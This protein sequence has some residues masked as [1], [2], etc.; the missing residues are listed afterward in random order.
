MSV[1][2]S[3]DSA[4]KQ[5]NET[6]ALTLRGLLRMLRVSTKQLCSE[7]WFH[8]IWIDSV[9]ICSKAVARANAET[10]VANA[11]VELLFGMLSLVSDSSIFD[12][13]C[14]DDV[15]I[16]NV[17]TLEYNKQQLWKLTVQFVPWIC[18][19]CNNV[20]LALTVLTKLDILYSK[21]KDFEFRYSENMRI[22]L[23]CM[24]AI[25]RPCSDLTICSD[26]KQKSLSREE[27]VD[28]KIMDFFRR[29]STVDQSLYAIFMSTLC[30][31]CFS[32]KSCKF[33]Y[34]CDNNSPDVQFEVGIRSQH[35]REQVC[36]FLLGEL[37]GNLT[38]KLSKST[39]VHLPNIVRR[40]FIID[41]G[42]NFLGSKYASI[43][44]GD[45]RIE[46]FE[47]LLLPRSSEVGF[48]LRI[49]RQKHSYRFWEG[50][51][52][53]WI[54]AG[55][56]V[57]SELK[58]LI[59][60]FKLFLHTTRPT[61]LACDLESLKLWLATL[62]GMVTGQIDPNETGKSNDD[63]FF[64]ELKSLFDCTFMAMSQQE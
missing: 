53:T 63:L 36:E 51:K 32:I 11:G 48:S 59:R 9:E 50:E 25:S 21:R 60:A 39:A 15:D 17:E 20:E 49:Q 45:A 55:T 27:T 41:V 47:T 5:W 26:A 61:D 13:E 62:F 40:R 42:S 3:R 33:V 16:L 12:E 23:N 28:N 35:L 14:R 37:D 2:H 58:I 22:L 34:S 52:Y 8:R 54:I 31:I 7:Q 38:L 6:R 46:S 4:H 24:L 10:E 43:Y 29:I 56:K 19:N 44:D 1:H 18:A 57:C 30:E 64:I